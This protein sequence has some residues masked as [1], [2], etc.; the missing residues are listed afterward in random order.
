MKLRGLDAEE[1]LGRKKR[2]QSCNGMFGLDTNLRGLERC[3]LRTSRKF[4]MRS[5]GF[6][7]MINESHCITSTQHSVVPQLGALHECALSRASRR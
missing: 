7:D 1:K 4:K 3:N 2:V 5:S 6:E